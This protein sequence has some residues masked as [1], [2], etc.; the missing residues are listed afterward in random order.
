MRRA[1]FVPAHRGRQPAQVDRARRDL[2]LEATR[3]EP[4]R[5]AEQ[6]AR[7]VVLDADAPRLQA[8]DD[9]IER[10][11]LGLAHFFV[12][13]DAQRE[14][15]QVR[16]A[17]EQAC[18]E[19]RQQ[20]VEVTLGHQSDEIDQARVG[21]V[22]QAL[23]QL[24]HGRLLELEQLRRIEAHVAATALTIVVLEI[25]AGGDA[26]RSVHEL[27]AAREVLELSGR[28]RDQLAGPLGQMLQRLRELDRPTEQGRAR[29]REHA[30]RMLAPKIAVV[31]LHAI[32]ALVVR[33]LA[34][35]GVEDRA[36]SIRPHIAGAHER[37]GLV[38]PDFA[39]ED[40]HLE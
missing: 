27:A 4:R 23:H 24:A 20:R 28:E 10:R 36:A 34:A 7:R 40:L 26:Q 32:T 13:V 12:G 3:R 6:L 21:L 17:R 22:T 9:P 33:D 38:R 30:E 14:S 8:R 35:F 16:A 5:L 15:L 31:H 25:V 11:R 18:F 29:V 19:L 2:R 1:R 37:R 39:L